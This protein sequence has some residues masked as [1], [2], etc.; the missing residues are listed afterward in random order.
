[1]TVL[2]GMFV[3]GCEHFTVRR[4]NYREV[5]SKALGETLFSGTLNVDV[6]VAIGIREDFRILG[7][8]TGEQNSG[9]QNPAICSYNGW[10]RATAIISLR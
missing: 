8:D 4:V 2:Q 5:S 6:G 7:R 9:V 10:G 3:Q 1:M